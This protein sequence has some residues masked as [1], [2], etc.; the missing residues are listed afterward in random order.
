MPTAT[1]IG[2][3]E[4]LANPIRTSVPSPFARLIVPP[5]ETLSKFVQ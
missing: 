5:P 4:R 1:A 3:G 2:P